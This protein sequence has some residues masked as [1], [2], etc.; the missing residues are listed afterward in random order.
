MTSG[1]RQVNYL[2]IMFFEEIEHQK[3]KFE[4][5]H[6]PAILTVKFSELVFRVV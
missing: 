6:L 5:S 3:I 2:F 4:E 1:K